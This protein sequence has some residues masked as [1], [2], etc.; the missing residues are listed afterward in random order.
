L[1]EAL[2]F[3]SIITMITI[4]KKNSVLKCKTFLFPGGEVGVKLESENGSDNLLGYLHEFV[5]YQ[6][7]VARLTS[8]NDIMELV[9]AVDALRRLD[10]TP[11]VL[12]MPYVPYARQ[13]RVCVPG[14]SFSLKAFANIINGL[15]FHRV[16][17]VDPH[18]D[19]VGAVFNNIHIITQKQ[20][21]HNFDSFVNTVISEK[22]LFISP[23]A[24]ANK[25][26]SELAA[27]F[28]HTSF[29]R[30]DK[31]RDLATGKIKETI[32]YAD[33]IEIPVVIAD[34][35]CDGGRTFIE[36]AKVLKS[37]GC[38]KVILYVTH[39]IFSQGF[40]T[41]LANGIDQIFTT[42][43]YKTQTGGLQN[44]FKLENLKLI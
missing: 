5:P 1:T 24:G 28:G 31:L 16:F 37:K 26:T 12:F 34:D 44:V 40:E 42:D 11:V 19:V 14:E 25:K 32:V 22:A 10:D 3:R 17:V 13:D 6:V 23:D 39:G 4:H 18:S 29:I 21:I 41:L 36:L 33:K 8:S 15:N 27:Y 20:I 35:I 30:A 2:I 38:P 7:V 43:S 9:M